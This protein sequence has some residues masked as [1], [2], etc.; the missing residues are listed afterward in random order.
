MIFKGPIELLIADI[1][2][3]LMYTVVPFLV[4]EYFL[5]ATYC[6]AFRDLERPKIPVVH[7]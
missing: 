1:E 6:C 3:A 2:L 7:A 5:I 4:I